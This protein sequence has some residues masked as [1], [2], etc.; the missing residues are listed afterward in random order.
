MSLYQVNPARKYFHFG[1]GMPPV[2]M[3]DSPA[4][5]PTPDAEMAPRH[6]LHPLPLPQP[7]LLRFAAW[8][9]ILYIIPSSIPSPFPSLLCLS[10][11]GIQL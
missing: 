10:R 7:P 11:T 3:E 2:E 4:P 5:P 6:R 9:F 8:A 1:G